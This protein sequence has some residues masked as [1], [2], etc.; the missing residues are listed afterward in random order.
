MEHSRL[1][2]GASALGQV[3]GQPLG[4]PYAS[5]Q[6]PMQLPTQPLQQPLQQLQAQQH[7]LPVGAPSF[8]SQ[9]TLFLANGPSFGNFPANVHWAMAD[10]VIQP[11]VYHHP[12]G[13]QPIGIP[14]SRTMGLQIEHV[15]GQPM[16]LD[17]SDYFGILQ[18][19]S[20]RLFLKPSLTSNDNNNRTAFFSCPPKVQFR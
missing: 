12:F 3:T 10:G 2:S 19:S 13:H 11:V 9:D 7:G 8:Y 16:G 20:S 14:T 17:R 15:I 18:C 1:S 4:F 5:M 6:Q